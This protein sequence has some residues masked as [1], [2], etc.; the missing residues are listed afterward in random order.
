M[1]VLGKAQSLHL[2]A[3]LR[4]L[5]ADRADRV[6]AY[7]DTAFPECCEFVAVK[8]QVGITLELQRI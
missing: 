5:R 7:Q 4:T 2:F 3:D 6:V 1:I 8:I